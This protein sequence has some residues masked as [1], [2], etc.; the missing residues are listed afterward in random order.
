MATDHAALLLLLNWMSP[1]F[2]IGAFAY[3]H[4]LEQAIA[5]GRITSAD[6]VEAWLSDSLQHGSGWNDAVLF[7]HCWSN[8]IEELN[9]LALALAGS[10][11]RYME[12]THL[13]RNFNIAAS[14][15]TDAEPTDQPMAYAIAAG[16]ACHAMGIHK[17]QAM[18]AF[19]QG[20]CAA[21]VSVA[22]RLVPLGQTNGL[23]VLR[24]LSPLIATIAER[25]AHATLDDLG[26]HCIAADIAAMQHETLQPR[27]FRT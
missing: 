2:P 19:L 14:V 27:I 18:I 21:L 6:D 24:N 26:G 23:K 17:D 20:F 10:A 3:S 12:S 11:E 4:G 15:W 16:S 1:T 9:D 7:Q 22:V 13:G 5:D 25:A 8:P